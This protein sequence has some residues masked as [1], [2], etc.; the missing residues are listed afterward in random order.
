M[1]ISIFIT[2]ANGDLGINCIIDITDINDPT[3]GVSY[4]NNILL[5]N[6]HTLR[7]KIVF[8]IL[9]CVGRHIHTPAQC[10]RLVLANTAPSDKTAGSAT[11]ITLYY[12]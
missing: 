5:F 6:D 12:M 2:R 1:I 3:N 11:R 8:H 4:S 7:L 9:A 10:V